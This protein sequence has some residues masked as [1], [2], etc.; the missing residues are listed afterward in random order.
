MGHPAKARARLEIGE[1]T[2]LYVILLL[3]LYDTVLVT[4][5]PTPT[6]AMLKAPA[7]ILGVKGVS[8]QHC[9]EVEGECE[10]L[11]GFCESLPS[12]FG[13]GL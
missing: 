8:N 10:N 4:A 1:K 3:C 7:M 6:P 9:K 2:P 11:R 5:L 12:S 13:P